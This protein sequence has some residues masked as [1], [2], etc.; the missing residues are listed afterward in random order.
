MGKD[1]VARSVCFMEEAM[2]YHGLSPG[3]E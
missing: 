2:G 1:E 3:I